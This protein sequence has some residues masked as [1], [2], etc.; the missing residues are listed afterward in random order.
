MNE[1]QKIIWRS[2]HQEMMREVTN[3]A[4]GAFMKEKLKKIWTSVYQEMMREVSSTNER[5]LIKEILKTI[6]T[7]IHKEM[8]SEV[9][10]RNERK[11]LKEELKKRWT[12]IHAEMM[13][14]LSDRMRMQLLKRKRRTMHLELMAVWFRMEYKKEMQQM[15]E[16]VRKEAEDARRE[17]LIN[18]KK[19]DMM[20][21]I[22]K[23]DTCN[24]GQKDKH[25]PQSDEI[26]TF[27]PR[28]LFLFNIE[29]FK[30]DSKHVE[31][32]QE[33]SSSQSAIKE[34]TPIVDE[35]STSLPKKKTLRTKIKKFFGFR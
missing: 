35:R 11:L 10:R 29:T 3:R 26:E 31:V 21:S 14:V 12:G 9:S 13:E 7:S 6:W 30:M 20:K 8:M 24:F 23:D 27:V 17:K 34:C 16:L 2:I 32:P 1:K 4:E 19:L 18:D 28:A 22:E 25:V 33:S 15:K 5:T